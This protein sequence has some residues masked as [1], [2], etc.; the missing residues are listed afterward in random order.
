MEWCRERKG[1][2]SLYQ[3]LELPVCYR[4]VQPEKVVAGGESRWVLVLP[5]TVV[6]AHEELKLEIGELRGNRSLEVSL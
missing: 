3:E 4:Y 1:K 5:K 6:G 2:K